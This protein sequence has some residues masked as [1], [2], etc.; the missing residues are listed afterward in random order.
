MGTAGT[1]AMGA[2]TG[3]ASGAAMGAMVGGPV[4]ALVGGGVGMIA[5]GIGGLGQAKADK[6]AKAALEAQQ[7]QIRNE[8][9]RRAQGVGKTRETFGDVWSFANKDI[10]AANKMKTGGEFY[11]P[12][13]PSKF[14]SL[15]KTVT[16]HGEIAGGVESQ[17]DAVRDAGQQQLTGGAQQAAVA[18]RASIA[19][20][21]LMGSSL[22]DSAK[23]QL[24]AQYAGGRANVAGATEGARQ[25]GWDAVRGQQ[26]QMEGMAN[27]GANIAPNQAATGAA[28]AIAGARAQMPVAMF[29]NLLNTGLGVFQQGALAEA[30]GGQGLAALGLPKLGVGPGSQNQ[31]QGAFTSGGSK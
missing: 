16:R 24:L 17:A 2:G 19:N 7:N 10:N 4:G 26:M 25:G 12:Q 22:A 11:D 28:S 6:A 14:Q 8:M 30:Q 29:G 1:V 21:G 15:K 9:R 27:A 31:A 5:G 3:A 20:R 18:N 13:D 23:Q